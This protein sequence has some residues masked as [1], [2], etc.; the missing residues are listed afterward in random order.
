MTRRGWGLFALISV[1]WGV[2]YLLIKVATAEVEPSIIAF[3]RIVIAAAVLL[4]LAIGTGALRQAYK[5][6]RVLLALSFLEVAVPFLLISYGEQHITSSL[7]G[8]LI[9]ADPLFIVLLATRFD[10]A[11]RASGSRLFGLGLG[12]IGVVALLGLN[13]GG[14][15]LALL[16]GGFV[17][18]AAVCYAAG[19][20][21]IKRVSDVPPVG[22]VAPSLALGALWLLPLAIPNFPAHLPS[23]PVVASLLALGLVC[24]A[25][26]FLTY[27][28]LIA[29]AGATRGSLITYVNP[30]VAVVLG[31][32]ILHEPVTLATLAGFALILTGCWLSTRSSRVADLVSAVPTRQVPAHQPAAVP[33]LLRSGRTE[34]G[35]PPPH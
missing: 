4:P 22:S 8:L 5:Y 3:A 2:P 15:S 25:M 20:L 35:P 11:E 19:A 14:D 9:A 7:A 29:E 12:F 16:G 1:L 21:L 31:V 13:P 18:L 23:A 32:A 33:E 34:D 17:L 28:S 24:T 10:S 6:W 26:G 30:A 27:F